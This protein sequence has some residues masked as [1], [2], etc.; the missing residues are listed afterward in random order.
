MA[1]KIRRVAYK[2]LK[3]KIILNIK[4][5]KPQ[6]FKSNFVFRSNFFE[7]SIMNNTNNHIMKTL[8]YLAKWK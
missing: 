2:V 3:K 1:K 4:Q 7:K 5:K 8:N 6:Y